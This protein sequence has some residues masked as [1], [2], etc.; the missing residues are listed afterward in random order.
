MY[1][2][3]KRATKELYNIFSYINLCNS[4]DTFSFERYDLEKIKSLI[5]TVETEVVKGRAKEA[6]RNASNAKSHY[7]YVTD[8]EK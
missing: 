7:I 6:E 8:K 4:L 5:E 2:E 3:L 1:E